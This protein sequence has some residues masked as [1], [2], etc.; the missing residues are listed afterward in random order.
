M[1]SRKPW[2]GVSPAFGWPSLLSHPQS[3]VT[4]CICAK[5]HPVTIDRASEGQAVLFLLLQATR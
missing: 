2:A 5:S 1:I 3:H 4:R